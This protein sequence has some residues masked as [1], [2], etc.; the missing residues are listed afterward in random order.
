MR[1]SAFFSL[2]VLTILL[3]T[4]QNAQAWGDLG[5]RVICKI[6]FRL[7]LPS[8]SAVIQALSDD[9]PNSC[10][11]PDHPRI[12]PEEHFINLPRDSS[13]LT[14]DA[15][16]LAAKCV[17][18]AIRDDT[19]LLSSKTSSTAERS[20]ALKSLAHWVGDV[21]QPLHVSFLDDRGGNQILAN[22][23]CRNLHA[24][25]DTCLV[26]EAVGDNIQKTVQDLV[27]EVTPQIA[28]DWNAT[29]PRDWVNESFAITRSPYTH[30]CIQTG[31]VCMQE[32]RFQF[33]QEYL[34][35]NRPVVLEQ[36][37]KAGVRLARI[38]DSA[39]SN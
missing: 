25:W 33:T 2:W 22:G 39:H 8:T 12:R 6:A 1:R 37:Q 3:T 34:D 38:L 30:Y 17:L 13:G 15:C 19:K 7:V 21:H 36:L 31:T 24:V 4:G 28:A 23:G 32:A 20:I 10:G 26:E 16:P 9:F 5:H 14:D 11:Y 35:I 18:S 27:D 29:T